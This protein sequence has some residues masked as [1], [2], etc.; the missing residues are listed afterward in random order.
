[1]KKLTI[2]LLSIT[3]LFGLIGCISDNNYTEYN[4]EQ[5]ITLRVVQT[6]NTRGISRPIP[7]G[8]RLEFVSGDLF[9]VN[10]QDV[11]IRHFSIVSGTALTATTVGIT[12]L[13]AGVT[14]ES[15]PSSIARVVISD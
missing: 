1:M 4:A 13:L 10:D 3:L 12:N 14:I 5:D 15:V 7:D 8:E 2:Q 9:M 6:T 11:I